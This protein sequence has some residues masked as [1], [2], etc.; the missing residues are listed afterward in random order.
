[1]LITG[2]FP[3]SQR[4]LEVLMY[5]A[6]C[7]RL[8]STPQVDKHVAANHRYSLKCATSTSSITS[9]LV[10]LHHLVDSICARRHDP[11]LRASVGFRFASKEVR[12]R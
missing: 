3:R 1:M 7:P 10:F 11:E 6:C 8:D 2:Q 12:S 9:L 5:V 4:C